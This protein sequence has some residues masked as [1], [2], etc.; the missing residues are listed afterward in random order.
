MHGDESKRG[1]G[2]AY[3]KQRVLPARGNDLKAEI[4][5]RTEEGNKKGEES[6]EK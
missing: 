2:C 3:V 1:N 6:L 4:A 5:A